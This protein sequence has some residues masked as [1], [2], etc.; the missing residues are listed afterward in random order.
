[1]EG[2]VEDELQRLQESRRRLVLAGEAERRAIERELHDGLQQHL[3][4][5]AVNVQLARKALESDVAAARELIEQL[6]RDVQDAIDSA[7]RL[8]QSI[9][10]PLLDA[11]GLAAALRAAAVSAGV[12]ASI[13]VP[14]GATYPP[15]IDAAV[16]ACC[17]T[18]LES[19]V[20]QATLTARSENDAVS[21]EV[22]FDG[23]LSDQAAERLRDRV[24]ALGGELTV[25]P[26]RVAAWF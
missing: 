2:H 5:L 13:N 23:E 9:Y 26:G 7:A 15:D 21:F 8:A 3:V 18:A 14:T 25:E 24:E 6:G 22:V 11:G 20:T 10:P 19:A 12:H 17:L 16:Y 1:M 4:A